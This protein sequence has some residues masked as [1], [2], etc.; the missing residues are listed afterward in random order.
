VRSVTLERLLP[1]STARVVAVP[2]EPRLLRKLM[3]FGIL[4]GAE[5][6]MLQST[7]TLVVRIGFTD[8]ALGSEIASL[9]AVE[10]LGEGD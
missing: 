3:A 4:P 2:H 9:I 6:T 10:V 5:L 1:G 7:P 8:V